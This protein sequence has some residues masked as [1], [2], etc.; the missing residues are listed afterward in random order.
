MFATAWTDF[1]R[2]WV[3]DQRPSLAEDSG[4]CTDMTL[5]TRMRYLACL[6][7]S[8]SAPLRI[9]AGRLAHSGPEVVLP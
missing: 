4:Q 2:R 9:L 3:S 5:T 7:D 1:G 8:S 6:C